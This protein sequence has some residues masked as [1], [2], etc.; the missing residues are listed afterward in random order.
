MPLG[1]VDEENEISFS[2][3]TS[4][5]RE[6]RDSSRQT[7][8]REKA[9][10]RKR[11]DQRKR[12]CERKRKKEIGAEKRK[13][14]N[15]LAQDSSANHAQGLMAALPMRCCLTHLYALSLSLHFFPLSAFSSCER[16]PASRQSADLASLSFPYPPSAFSIATE[17]KVRR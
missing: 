16:S 3:C 4:P 1:G 11:I 9:K 8:S 2:Y 5:P 10:E 12:E 14:D 15:G 17:Q 7:K 6:Q 13:I